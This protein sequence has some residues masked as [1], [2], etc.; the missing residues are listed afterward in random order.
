MPGKVDGDDVELKAV[1]QAVKFLERDA[2]A[3]RLAAEGM[4]LPF[5]QAC[6]PLVQRVLVQV[7]CAVVN[8]K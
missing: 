4:D 8:P 7:A 5:E 1:R 6:E 3:A 2:A